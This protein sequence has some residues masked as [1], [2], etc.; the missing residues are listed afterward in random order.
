MKKITILFLL[1]LNFSGFSQCP[2]NNTF[3]LDLTPTAEG[4][5]ASDACVWGGDLITSNVI[6]GETYIISLCNNT[7]FDDS[8]I[9]LYDTA[10]A[11]V[12][13]YNDD[14]CGLYSEVIW[15]ATY[16]GVLNVVVDEYNCMDNTNC[17]ELGITWEN[18]LNTENFNKKKTIFYP[19]PI[20]DI[21]TFDLL[22]DEKIKVS[23]YETSGRLLLFKEI[24]SETKTL[25]LSNLD[26]GVYQMEINNREGI[27]YEKI[28]KE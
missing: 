13:G 14:F 4:D 24:N 7:G 28:I 12:L 18:N 27:N 20:K 23:I 3:Y 26:S 21:L 5:T 2:F 17:M 9:T 25:D 10:G 1:T 16:T 6:S 11:T 8:Q 15:T 19:N 22:N